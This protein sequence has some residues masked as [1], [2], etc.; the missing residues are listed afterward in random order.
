M[1]FGWRMT[2][3]RDSLKL[4]VRYH[5]TAMYI[6]SIFYFHLSFRHFL[7]SP[8]SRLRSLLC[9]HC[10]AKNSPACRYNAKRYVAFFPLALPPSSCHFSLLHSSCPLFLVYFLLLAPFPLSPK[11]LLCPALLCHALLEWT[12]CLHC[13]FAACLP[14]QYVPFSR[15]ALACLSLSLSSPFFPLCFFFHVCW[16]AVARVHG[17]REAMAAVLYLIHSFHSLSSH[18]CSPAQCS[19]LLELSA[20]FF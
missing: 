15:L 14:A 6:V 4:W 1:E 8:P 16:S 18:P 9:C 5:A 3:A 7:F 20:P 19:N 11:L 2:A 10:L 12:A 17:Y 13:T